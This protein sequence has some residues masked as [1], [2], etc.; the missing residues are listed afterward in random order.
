[1]AYTHPMYPR[2]HLLANSPGLLR[3]MGTIFEG[4]L[5]QWMGVYHAWAIEQSMRSS[6]VWP[7]HGTDWSPKTNFTHGKGWGVAMEVVLFTHLS[8]RKVPDN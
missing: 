6:T 7:T 4:E 5:P 3:D 2:W 8:H 1:M